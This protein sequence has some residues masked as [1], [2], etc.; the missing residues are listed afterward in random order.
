MATMRLVQKLRVPEV[1]TGRQ[2]GGRRSRESKNQ[3]LAG[4]SS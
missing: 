3:L 1:V 2:S 4:S